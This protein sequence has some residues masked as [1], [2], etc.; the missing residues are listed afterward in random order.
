M[1]A[2]G[3]GTQYAMKFTFSDNVKGSG[4][5]TTSNATK[6]DTDKSST[7]AQTREEDHSSSDS[8]SSSSSSSSS[9]SSSSSRTITTSSN[10]GVHR[11]AHSTSDLIDQLPNTVSVCFYNIKSYELIALL[12]D[13]V[14]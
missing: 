2:A 1:L 10:S 6:G 13:K 3:V 5:G 4:V 9:G 7:G 14:R 8:S 12:S 11:L